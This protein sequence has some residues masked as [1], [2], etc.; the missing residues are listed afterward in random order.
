MYSSPKQKPFT[1][2]DPADK[3]PLKAI[4]SKS[5]IVIKFDDENKEFTIAT[6]GS[7]TIIV[8]DKDKKITIKDQ[9]SNTIIMSDSGIAMNS[10]KDITISA[11]Q[12]L[13]LKG[14]QGVQIAASG[15]DVE[16]KGINIKET[17]SA[18]YTSQ[19]ATA[20]VSGSGEL[21]LKGGIVMI[22]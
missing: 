18:Q 17:A 10:S 20:Q 12:K 16:L 7:N 1:G 5:G 14:N 15:G 8:S 2:L 21:T 22:N 3:N 9:N 11:S 4:V 6:P 13:I 19:G